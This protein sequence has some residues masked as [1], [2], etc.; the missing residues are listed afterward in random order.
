MKDIEGFEGLYAAHR[1]GKIWGYRQ[2]KF[3]KP[4]LIGHGYECVSLY[5]IPQK[6]EKFLVHRLIA[7][8]FIP[9]PLNL[10]EVNHRNGKIR[11]NQPKNL[12]WVT[13]KQNKRHAWENGFY[14]HNKLT[15]KQV[16]EIRKRYKGK[17]GIKQSELALEYGITQAQVSWI[18][19]GKGWVHIL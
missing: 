18:I 4:W 14:T 16:I 2:K 10:L 7:Q 12:E 8:A 5:R 1:S 17:G 3:L 11:K 15:K 9:N 6:N 19:T 13:S